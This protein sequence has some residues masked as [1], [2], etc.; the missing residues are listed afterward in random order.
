MCIRDSAYLFKRWMSFLQELN[1]EVNPD[2]FV[3]A[4]IYNEKKEPS[5]ARIRQTWRKIVDQLMSE[6]KLKGHKFSDRKY[7]LYSMRS[8]FIED[9]LLRRTDLYLLARVSGHSVT[10]LM[11]SYERLD[12]RQRAQE[13][14]NIEYG[15]KK[16]ADPQVINLFKN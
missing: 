15:K 13:L 14:T 16:A 4:Q 3:F 7:T 8:T 2:D 12:I 10:T 1:V 11:E 6:G 9:H 5:Q